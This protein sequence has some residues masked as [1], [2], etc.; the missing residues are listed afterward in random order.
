MKTLNLLQFIFEILVGVGYLFGL[1]PL[2]YLISFWWVMPLTIANL[3]FSIISKNRT[4]HLT[5]TNVL[6][7]WLSLIPVLGYMT[8]VV[9]FVMSVTSAIVISKEF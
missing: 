9:G 7:A 8:R 4:L 6:M 5:I 2:V 1:I 3:V